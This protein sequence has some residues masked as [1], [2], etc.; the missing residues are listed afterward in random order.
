MAQS[1]DENN[2]WFVLDT[3]R[4]RR[5]KREA[6]AKSFRQN[7]TD[8]AIGHFQSNI[9]RTSHQF[10][11]GNEHLYLK[12]LDVDPLVKTFRTQPPST[13]Y[14]LD[15]EERTYTADS[16][17]TLKDGHF[18]RAY[19]EV[20]EQ[21]T[22][23]DPEFVE[24]WPRIDQAISK[25]NASFIVIT[26]E[27]LKAE[28]RRSNVHAL[29]MHRGYRPTSDLIYRIQRAFEAAST[30]PFADIVA[31]DPDP[32]FGKHNII[33]L[34]YQRL[35]SFDLTKTLNDATPIFLVA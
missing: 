10:H 19:V 16:L 12:L 34:I 21:E 26:D 4:P 22:A 8:R 9:T 13:S 5:A 31:L 27:Y 33:N 17:V 30:L 32:V 25:L 14:F 28:P 1:H 15:G 29:H 3:R 6:F 7:R 2:G 23:T 24:R 18:C 35:I 20:K 11:S